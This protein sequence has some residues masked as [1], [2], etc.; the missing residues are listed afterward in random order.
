MS[1][2]KKYFDGLRAVAIISVIIYHAN[3]NFFNYKLFSGG[4]LGIDIF[5]VISGYLITFVIVNDF[6]KN[7]KFSILNFADKRIRRIFPV[8]I[9]IIIF[10]INL[11]AGDGFEPPTSRL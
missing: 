11:V 4:Y 2:Y 9:L 6:E 3:I 5:F 7:K 1:T 8:L 10:L